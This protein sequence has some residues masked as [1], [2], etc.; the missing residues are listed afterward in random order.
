MAY[1]FAQKFWPNPAL[2]SDAVKS[3]APVSLGVMRQASIEV[4]D[5]ESFKS[6]ILRYG[7]NLFPAF[8][9]SG[10]W[11]THVS[12]DFRYVRLK[13]PL[14]LKTR[15]YVG[16]LCGGNMYSAVDG[17]YLVMLLKNLGSDYLV[18][19]KAA[20]IRYKRPAKGT[21][22]A[23]FRLTEDELQQIKHEVARQGKVDREYLIELME[24]SGVV[25][26]EVIKTIHVKQKVA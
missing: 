20:A 13:I 18:W 26:A 15:N 21:L 10:G 24:A 2:H 7:F 3:A 14:T 12:T 8:R 23:E 5:D 11:L 17:V 1:G 22:F 19:D 16:T 9:S 4:V 6:K 25:C